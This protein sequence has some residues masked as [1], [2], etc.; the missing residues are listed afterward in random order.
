[1]SA[2]I[3]RMAMTTAPAAASPNA[4]HRQRPSLERTPGRPDQRLYA[5]KQKGRNRIES[6]G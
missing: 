2:R 4:G 6:V 3:G 5:A 1:M